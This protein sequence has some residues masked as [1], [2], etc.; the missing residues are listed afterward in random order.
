MDSEN[1]AVFS[2]KPCIKVHNTVGM[3]KVLF[4]TA[5]DVVYKE[6]KELLASSANS[7]EQVLE[8]LSDNY[9]TKKIFQEVSQLIL[10]GLMPY[11][12]LHPYLLQNKMPFLIK[13]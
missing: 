10:T 3:V 13:I 4:D 2:N 6:V 1:Q 7:V 5:M 8:A 9:Q 12:L 11:D